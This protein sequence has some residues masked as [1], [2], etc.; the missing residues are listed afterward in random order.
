MTNNAIQWHSDFAKQFD[1]K[2]KSSRSF[3][4]RFTLWEALIKKYCNENSVVA[5]VGCGS[6]ILTI[7]AAKYCEHVFGFDASQEMLKI[8]ENKKKK[9]GLK[10]VDFIES[11]IESLD[12]SQ[13]KSVDL[14]LCSSVLEYVDDFWRVFDCISRLLNIGGIMIFSVPNRKSIYRKFE[15]FSFSISGSPKYFAFVNNVFDI[16]SLVTG[17]SGRG[18]DLIESG[19]FS[20]TPLLSKIMQITHTPQYSENMLYLV[21][22]KKSENLG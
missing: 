16:N 8:C 10:N 6:G 11:K 20:K 2:Y 12:I 14:V 13:F 15:K 17:V 3:I 5:D 7:T 19:F 21:C 22:K 9:S 18:F 4:E 1:N